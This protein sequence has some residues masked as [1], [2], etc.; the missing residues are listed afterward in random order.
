MLPIALITIA[1][2]LLGLGSS[3]LNSQ[4]IN[5]FNL[6]NVLETNTVFYLI[7]NIMKRIGGIVFSNIPI[8]FAISTAIGMAKKEK[9]VAIFS[10]VISVFVM[11]ETIS[12]FLKL[13]G[14]LAPGV[15]HEGSTATVCGIQSLEM[16]VFGGILVGLGVAY[17]HNKFYTIKLS[18]IISFLSGTKFVPI[19]SCFCYMLVGG[20]ISLIWPSI[21]AG[22]YPLG[23]LVLASKYTGTLVYGIIERVLIPFGLDHVFRTPFWQ[24]ALGGAEIIDNHYVTGIQNILFSE[25]ASTNTSKFN[26]N[27][28]RF[29]SGRFPLTIFGLP[30]AALAIYQN[31]KS[32]KK[33]NIVGLMLFVAITSAVTGVTEPIEFIILFFAPI[34]YGIHC[35]FAGL[36]FVLMHLLKVTV[37][38][39]FSGGLID[40]LLC[41]ILPGNNKTNWIYIIP[42]GVGYAITYYFVFKFVIRKFKLKTPGREKDTSELNSDS[43]KEQNF[44][45]NDIIPFTIVKGLGGIENII[46]IDYY[47]TSLI[48][49]VK[50]E[51]AVDED[52][53]K[54][55]GCVGVIKKGD[56]IQVVFGPRVAVIKNELEEYISSVSTQN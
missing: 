54:K 27:I 35:L 50:D 22:I 4:I 21:Q 5:Y 30:S 49:K 34:L 38:L 31:A 52:I 7:F 46:D 28:A 51:S 42:V 18:G 48:V 3:L 43:I 45:S 23:G 19:I 33:K 12:L 47:A 53:V 36:S 15:L 40:L 14:K 11:H 26:I 44:S 20:A 56:G 39:T 25:L 16:G 8:L 13:N 10:T 24:T 2:F 1:G 37:G 17:L 41:G 32:S 29:M 9:S 6:Q 55:S